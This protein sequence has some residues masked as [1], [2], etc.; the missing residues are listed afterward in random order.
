MYTREEIINILDDIE[1][2]SICVIKDDKENFIID[3]EFVNIN[4]EKFLINELY[5][6]DYIGIKIAMGVATQEEYSKE[7]AYTEMIRE[8]IRKLK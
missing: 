7:I 3:K 4:K 8:F 5:K 2:K 6:Y 1:N